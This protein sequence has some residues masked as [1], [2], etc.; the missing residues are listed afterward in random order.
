MHLKKRIIIKMKKHERVKRSAAQQQQP[1]EAKF[2]GLPLCTK[3]ALA[4]A[5]SALDE[6]ILSFLLLC[7]CV[8]EC[9]YSYIILKTHIS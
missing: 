4:Q 1:L 8:S 2:I 9:V 5:L 3:K 7:V 6:N